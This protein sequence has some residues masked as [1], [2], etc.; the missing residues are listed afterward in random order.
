MCV[1]SMIYDHYSPKFPDVWPTPILPNDAWA[2]PITP[3]PVLSQVN[4]FHLISQ[5]EVDS[6]R[7]LIKDFRTALEAAKTVDRLTNQPDCEDP[8]KK[9]LEERVTVLEQQVAQL[10]RMKKS[11]EKNKKV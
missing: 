4:P 11:S 7:A 5:E 8:E 10:L 6:L 2:V 1:V 9:K 3:Q